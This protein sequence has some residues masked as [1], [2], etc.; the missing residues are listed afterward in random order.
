MMWLQRTWMSKHLRSPSRFSARGRNGQW[1][2]LPQVQIV[3]A[4][5]GSIDAF[6]GLCRNGFLKR[7]RIAERFN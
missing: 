6:E 5:G 3:R 2:R 1:A 7:H 4:K